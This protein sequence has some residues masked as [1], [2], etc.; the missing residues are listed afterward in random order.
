MASKI[1][2]AGIIDCMIVDDDRLVFIVQKGQLG[3]AIGIKAKNIE[4]LR[5]L[6]KKNIKFVEYTEDKE[7]F[8]VNLFKPYKVNNIVLEGNDDSPIAKVE[9][10]RNEKSK[11]IGKGGKNID[12][13]RQLASRHHNI[14]DVQ[15]K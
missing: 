11:I 8:V 2:K 7:Q 9:V 12:I 6:F 15:I 10:D 5:N 3:I 14:K 13:I 4:K 1:T